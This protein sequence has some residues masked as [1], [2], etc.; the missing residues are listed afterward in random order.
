MNM[1]PGPPSREKDAPLVAIYNNLETFLKF[2]QRT[3]DPDIFQ[4][5]RFRG[6]RGLF[7]LGDPKLLFV[8]AA[9]PASAEQVCRRWGYPGTVILAP[10]EPT[11]QL[12]LDI[13]RER[14]L[15]D[16]ILE[17]A[18]P[19][20]AIR[21]V[22]YATTPEVYRL[23]DGLRE[24][25]LMVH[26]PES[27]APEN[28][29]L[30]DF[31]DTKSGFRAI[32]S[33]CL[34]S[35]DIFPQGFVCR[36]IAH[37]AGAVGWFQN[38]GHACVVKADGGESG[39]GH[40]F[41]SPDQEEKESVL[42]ALQDNPFLQN[43]LIIV[44]EYI[45]S[46]VHLSPSLEFTVPPA[47]LGAPQITYASKQLFSEF[48]R[49][50]GV[51]ISRTLQEAAWYPLL[52]ERGMKIA[53]HLQDMGYIGPFDLDA[54]VDEKD[55]PYLLEL[56]TRRTGGTY[57]HEFARFTFGP[58]YPQKVAVLSRNAVFSHGITNL[59]ELLDRLSD[60]LFPDYTSAGGGVVITVTSTLSAGEFGCI[61]VASDEIQITKLNE[62]LIE[63][64]ESRQVRELD[65]IK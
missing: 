64:L 48:G 1:E 34:S 53:N 65:Q 20:R 60:L 36:D 31:A 61:L 16:R 50:A 12:C 27:P 9:S 8:T 41:F 21:L 29:W 49:F 13:L 55:H 24:A 25:G 58:D 46:R 7:W 4:K 19:A 59:D 40:L 17:H 39:I 6:D 18:G 42:K 10:D 47:G 14:R 51:L 30:R 5:R 52:V 56:N 45:P 43:D 23:A 11:P 22:P 32:A 35:T 33:Q 26:L 57:V 28:H 54:V 3:K 15:F 44:E 2:L 63:R 62:A 38:H 37:A